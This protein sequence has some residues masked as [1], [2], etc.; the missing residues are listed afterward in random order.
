MKIL[1]LLAMLWTGIIRCGN[2]MAT[3]EKEADTGLSE[4][5]VILPP[6]GFNIKLSLLLIISTIVNLLVFK[7]LIN[8]KNYIKRKR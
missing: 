5:I 3:G 2:Y 8:Y 7:Y 6:T 4:D 1:I